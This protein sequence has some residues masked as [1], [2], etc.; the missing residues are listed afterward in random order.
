MGSFFLLNPDISPSALH[1]TT[2]QDDVSAP[3][4]KNDFLVHIAQDLSELEL[5]LEDL[6]LFAA[7]GFQGKF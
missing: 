1:M 7:T 2:Y 3:V 5:R 6:L 4:H